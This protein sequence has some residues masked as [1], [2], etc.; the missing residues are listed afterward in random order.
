MNGTKMKR[1]L[2]Y[3]AFVSPAA[4]LFA[5][6]IVL[7]FVRAFLYS[8][9]DWDGIGREM[10]WVGPANY[11]RAFEETAFRASVWFTAR[12]VAVTAVLL[13]VLGLLLALAVNVKLKT[14][15]F[16][17][18]AFFLPTVIVPV[19]VGYLWG[20]IIVQLLPDIGEWTGI[21]ILQKNWLSLPDYAFIS[22]AAVFVWQHVGYYMV[23]Y[24]AALQGVPRDLLEAAAMDGA[25]RWGTFRSVVIPLIRPAVTVCTFLAVAAGF[26]SFD[27][28]Y[29]LTQGGPFGTTESL[30][31]QIYKDA[32][33][34]NLFSYASAKAILFFAALSAVTLIQVAYMKRK[35]VQL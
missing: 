15:H 1:A 2:T 21:R 7:P 25:G 10:A 12:F 14:G 30:T 13:N 16:A 28:N 3:L 5:V 4:A 31:L 32:F 29:S 23:I 35:E 19:L 24:L 18:T 34:R 11:L 22:I 9:Q 33:Q 27:L 17:R 6:F 20:F 26:K 8:F